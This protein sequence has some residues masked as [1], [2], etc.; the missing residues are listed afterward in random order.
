MTELSPTKLESVPENL[1]EF[2]EL[3]QDF[4]G[5]TM[6]GKGQPRQNELHV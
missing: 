3:E 1:D 4:K 6:T 5:D 2:K